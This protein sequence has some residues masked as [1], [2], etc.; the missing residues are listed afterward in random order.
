L[1]VILTFIFLRLYSS[2]LTNTN[3]HKTMLPKSHKI[4]LNIFSLFLAIFVLLPANS[5][6]L[7]DEGIDQPSLYE[8]I[9]KKYGPDHELVN[10]I[11]YH[12]RYHEV[13]NH[14]YFI[15]ERP[16]PGNIIISGKKF[17]NV[18][19]SYDIYSQY[20]I[21]DYQ[22]SDRGIYKVILNPEHTDAFDIDE[23][24]FEK[25]ILDEQGP[26]FYQVIKINDL[27][28]YIHWKKELQVVIKNLQY[29]KYFTDSERTYFLNLNDNLF[30]FRNRKTFVSLFSGISENKIRKY[31][32]QNAINF[33]KVTPKELTDL[34]EFISSVM[35]STSG[36][37]I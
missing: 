36:N 8:Y 25:L 17:K 22:N 9:L 34:L 12:N 37:K 29:V 6:S 19:I 2:N 27:T 30:P 7:D 16:L 14:P 23:N 11:Q 20:L 21:L 4:T 5:Q 24:Y 15:C 3:F 35:I 33:R 31:L 10:G 28:C 26:L 32:K 1:T 13:Q 18:L